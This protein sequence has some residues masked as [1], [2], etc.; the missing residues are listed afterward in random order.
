[1]NYNDKTETRRVSDV[2]KRKISILTATT[3]AHKL[4]IVRALWLSTSETSSSYQ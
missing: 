1:M 3:G 4:T 2:I